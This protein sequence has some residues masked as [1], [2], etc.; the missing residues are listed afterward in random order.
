MDLLEWLQKR[1]TKMTRGLEHLPYEDRLRELGLFSLEK[2]RLWGDLIT[3]FQ[4]LKGPYR[5]DGEGLFMRECSDRTRELDIPFQERY[6]PDGKSPEEKSKNDQRL[7]KPP[8]AYKETLKKARL[9]LIVAALKIQ[10][11]R[12]YKPGKHPLTIYD[13]IV[14]TQVER[15]MFWKY[16]LYSISLEKIANRTLGCIRRIMASRSRE[17]ILPLYYALVRPHLEYCVQLW[18]PQHRKDMDLLEWLQ[19]RDTKMT[20]G[21]EYLPYEERLRELGL[22]SL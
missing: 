20:R 11:H 5:R 16:L 14:S 9:L 18:S 21:M 1:D 13:S 17:V 4:Y 7:K 22:F 10:R 15:S 2:R 8:M 3:T 6:E 12:Q 19:R